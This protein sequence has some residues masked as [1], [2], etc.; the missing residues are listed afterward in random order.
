MSKYIL[1]EEIREGRLM[2]VY[3]VWYSPF[4]YGANDGILSVH[5]NE[6]SAIKL[7]EDLMN[8]REGDL[9]DTYYYTIEKVI[10]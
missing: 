9:S 6:S 3:I 4:D 7:V 2:V 8:D 10:D 1:T 5:I